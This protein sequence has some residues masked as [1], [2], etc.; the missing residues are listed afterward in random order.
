MR[1]KNEG[2]QKVAFLAK[3]SEVSPN[4]LFLVMGGTTYPSPEYCMIRTE[5]SGI[6]WGGIYVLEYIKSGKGYIETNGERY[7]VSE[8][9]TVFMNAKRQ[10]TY[11][12]DKEQPYTKLWVNFT[13]P[14]TAGVVGGLSLNE[15]VYIFKYNSEP[16]I[17]EIHHLR[18]G[19]TRSNYGESYNRMA[20]LI[21]R[22]LLAANSEA[23]QMITGR[24]PPPPPEQAKEY[25]RSLP[26][27]TVTLD[28]VAAELGVNKNYLIHSYKKRYGIAPNQYIIFRKAEAA[29]EM[30]A[31]KK[32]SIKETA[33]ALRYSSTQHFSKSFKSAVG[34]SPGEYRALHT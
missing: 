13:G 27:P 20:E 31:A 9:H 22:M 8:G 4:G 17:K 16:L 7:E 11:Y 32:M 6:F 21:L 18:T 15:N 28:E 12:S 1:K 24:K 23:K 2:N 25:I 3:S 29:K 19:L 14:L 34:V 5:R 26:L 33:D 30:L 10:I